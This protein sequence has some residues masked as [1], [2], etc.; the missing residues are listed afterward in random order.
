MAAKFSPAL[1]VKYLKHIPTPIIEDLDSKLFLKVAE[2]VVAKEH[3]KSY[4]ELVKAFAKA[5]NLA[6]LEALTKVSTLREFAAS[7]L[8][9]CEVNTQLQFVRNAL[10][11]YSYELDACLKKLSSPSLFGKKRASKLPKSFFLMRG[12]ILLK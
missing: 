1:I 7:V 2:E 8:P 5:V 6:G 11:D 9:L 10:K 3:E 4:D 12:H